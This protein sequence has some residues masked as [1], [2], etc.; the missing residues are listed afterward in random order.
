MKKMYLFGATLAFALMCISGHSQ[1]NRLQEA[2]SQPGFSLPTKVVKSNRADLAKGGDLEVYESWDFENGIDEWTATGE[3]DDL[4]FY[5][6]P[7]TSPNGYDPAA[8]LDIPV[9]GDFLPNYFGAG[10]PVTAPSMDNGF[11]MIDADRWNSTATAPDDPAGPNTTANPVDAQI[12]SPTFSLDGVEFAQISFYQG[13]RQCCE[14]N[15]S[16]A[17]ELSVDDGD[18]WIPFDAY[19]GSFNVGF[20]GLTAVNISTVLQQT[21]DLSACKIRFNFTQGGSTHYY[22]A[23]DDINIAEIPQ[24]DLAAG[25]TWYNDWFVVPG[26]APATDYYNAF[27]YRV[28]PEYVPRPLTFGM[29]VNNNGVS[30]QTDVKLFVTVTLPD[31]TTL[32]D[33]ESDPIILASFATDTIY[34][35]NVEFGPEDGQIPI[36][37]GDYT[38]DYRVEQAEE[39]FLPEDNVGNARSNR[40]S[41]DASNDGFGIF[42]NEED[43][44]TALVFPDLGQDCIWSTAYVF[45]EP[46]VE[47]A[48]ITHVEIAL[49]FNEGFAETIAG[50]LIYFNVRSGAV[51]DEDDENPDTFT[52]VFFD[53]ENPLEYGGEDIE[54][55]IQ[56][57]DIWNADGDLP[58]IFTSF[59]LPEPIMIN[60][61]EVYAAEIRVPNAGGVQIVSPAI[62]GDEEEFATLA[63]SFAD[64]AWS[65]LGTNLAVMR[66]RTDEIL[67][68]DDVSYESG[69]QLLQNYPNPA[70]DITRIQYRLD[71]TSDVTFEVFDITGKLVHSEDHGRIPAG[72]AHTFNFDVNDLGAGV[73]TYGIVSNGERVTRKL[74]V[75]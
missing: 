57:A 33:F 47:N 11:L 37:E 69:I 4:W 52:E 38:F 8:A 43:Q 23:I 46:Q 68:V 55:E 61:G 24:N 29:E 44:Y 45:T 59:L 42:S 58:Y 53:S 16:M 41:T 56:E 51:L 10:E 36:Q 73:Y 71:E 34:I 26:D 67:S 63:Y 14:T 22:W 30:P 32:P 28:T 62:N 74:I 70:N 50:N 49:Q 72:V 7:T 60:A 64:G 15:S 48:V 9:Y 40:F 12:E 39:D 31:E 2:K 6:F 66:L 27:E 35:P 17:V 20:D 18:S 54:Y 25:Q 19:T 3:Q 65:N 13:V 21:D 1:E 5:A 75:E